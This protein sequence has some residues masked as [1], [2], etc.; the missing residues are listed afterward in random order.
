MTQ[1]QQQ[2]QSGEPKQRGGERRTG[3]SASAGSEQTTVVE[4][5]ERGRTSVADVVV[6]KVAS[7]AA[8]RVSGVRDLGGAV[9]RRFGS[10]RERVPGSRGPST[11]QGVSVE[12]GE[13][14][15]AV[16]LV[17]LVDY[18]V[19]IPEVARE[20]RRGVITSVEETTGLEVVEVNIDVS[21]VH[22]PGEEQAPEQAR[23]T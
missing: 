10:V 4:N 3:Q 9:Q 14:Q 22:V 2:E 8:R 15:A 13:Q 12:V 16:D 5:R 7:M 23:V 1:Q 6:T 17:L 11:G 19:S 18:G 21:D 20:V